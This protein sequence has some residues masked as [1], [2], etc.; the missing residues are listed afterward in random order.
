MSDTAE[1]LAGTLLVLLILAAGVSQLWWARN[2]DVG[3]QI[4]AY[5]TALG[6]AALALWSVQTLV[7]RRVY[8]RRRSRAERK[9]A[10]REKVLKRW[11]SGT[12]QAAKLT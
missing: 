5:F 7:Q 11:Q 4:L 8:G 2:M 10:A 9:S 1:R 12:D 3:A 6:G